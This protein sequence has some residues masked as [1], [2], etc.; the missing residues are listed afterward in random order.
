M[1]D[2]HNHSNYSDGLYEPSKVIENAVRDGLS[3]VALCDHDCTWGLAEAKRKAAELGIGFVPGIEL[4][5]NVD[6]DKDHAEEIHMLGLFVE[7]TAHLEDIHARVKQ[8]KDAFSY[9][10]A[11]AIRKHIGIP[12]EV[13]DMRRSFHGAISMGAFGEYMVQ[14]GMIEKFTDRKK[15]TKQLIAE[16]KLHAKPEFGIS[17][18]EGIEAIH[19]A[20][21]FA[22]LAHPF[23]T[24]LEDRVLFERIKEYKA[25]GLDGLECF[26]KKYKAEN[27]AENIRKSLQMASILGLL[28]SGG[29]DYHRD[30]SHPRFQNGGDIPDQVLTDLREA[31]VM[32]NAEYQKRLV[33]SYARVHE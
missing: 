22:I 19:G 33:A 5:I 2:L 28:V 30:S 26:Y 23:R 8:E 17:A 21:G 18:E 7:P 1:I 25:K 14:H 29:S 13:D 12:V 16:G 3:A 4:T 11:A 6:G 24:K 10:L 31:R 15:M 20:G 32:R 9:D 27:E